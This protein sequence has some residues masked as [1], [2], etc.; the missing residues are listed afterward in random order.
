[1][2]YEEN[3]CFWSCNH[4]NIADRFRDFLADLSVGA[5]LGHRMEQRRR[6]SKDSDSDRRHILF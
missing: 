4:W 2:S 6:E 1:M 3:I 5:R